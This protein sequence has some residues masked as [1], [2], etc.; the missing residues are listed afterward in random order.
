MFFKKPV[1]KVDKIESLYHSYGKL[2]FVVAFEILENQHAAEDAIHK[3]FEILLRGNLEKIAQPESIA[4]RNYLCTI[5]RN[6]ALKLYNKQKRHDLNNTDEI[7]LSP[8]NVFTPE[9]L[10]LNKEAVKNV[11]DA[12]YHMDIKYREVLLL[13]RVHKL[14]ITEI[15]EITGLQSETVKKRLQ[16]A[17]HILKKELERR[18]IANEKY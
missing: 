1:N 9:D 11:S 14:S 10:V 18:K 6:V 13:S 3:T 7:E 5:C 2:L 17:K 8:K 12:I 15:S 16:R 4:T